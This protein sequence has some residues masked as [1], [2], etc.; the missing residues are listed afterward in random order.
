MHCLSKGIL[1]QTRIGHYDH[2]RIQYIFFSYLVNVISPYSGGCMTTQGHLSL[3]SHLCRHLTWCF[4]KTDCNHVICFVLA[5]SHL[6]SRVF[7]REF[8]MGK[9]FSFIKTD[10]SRLC[11]LSLFRQGYSLNSCS[12][13]RSAGNKPTVLGGYVIFCSLGLLFAYKQQLK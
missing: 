13:S 2:V 7:W 1:S 6:R 3:N 10:V 8:I 4:S 12:T 5:W 11:V 9:C